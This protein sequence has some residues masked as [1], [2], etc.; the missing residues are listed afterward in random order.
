MLTPLA[1]GF[2][3]QL[4]L[5]WTHGWSQPRHLGAGNRLTGYQ[6]TVLPSGKV[7]LVYGQEV[8]GNTRLAVSTYDMQRSSITEQGTLEV[9]GLR[10]YALLSAE[11]L[12]YLAVLRRDS[13]ATYEPWHFEL[14]LLPDNEGTAFRKVASFQRLGVASD[15]VLAAMGPDRI[16]WSWSGSGMGLRNIHVLV[17]DKAGEIHDQFVLDHPDTADRYPSLLT[18]VPDRIYLT[19][20]RDNA[21]F[22]EVFYRGLTLGS[23]DLSE[24]LSLGRASPDAP[25]PQLVAS[26]EGA[27]IIFWAQ[28]LR[29]PGRGQGAAIYTGEIAHMGQW[30]QDLRPATQISGSVVRLSVDGSDPL[31]LIWLTDISGS[32]QIEYAVQSAAGELVREGPVTRGSENRFLPRL[33]VTDVGRLVVY[34]EYTQTSLILYGVDD[35]RPAKAPLSYWLGLDQNSP[36]GDAAFRYVTLIGSAVGLSV[37]AGL[38]LIFAALAVLALSVFLKGDDP[39]SQFPATTIM[40]AILVLLKRAGGLLYYGAVHVPGTAGLVILVGSA[41]FAL[42]SSRMMRRH[43]HG[44]VSLVLCGFLFMAA[45]FFAS[46]YVGGLLP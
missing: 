26:A 38:S 7:V 12:A 37:L 24:P 36:L 20:Y 28:P 43:V 23:K 6:S 8:S 15:I 1:L 31:G 35:L 25:R 3:A 2:A 29:V 32:L 22:S 4:P 41:F 16:V 21:M 14:W 45:D 30:I 19:Y 5:G 44:V 42:M 34:A 33:H 11:G 18:E 27:T 9:E 39:L 10:E 40:L 46:L 13:E 17:H